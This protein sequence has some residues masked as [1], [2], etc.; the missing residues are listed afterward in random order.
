M[1]LFHFHFSPEQLLLP[2]HLRCNYI[3]IYIPL[4]SIFPLSLSTIFS[5]AA[6]SIMFGYTVYGHFCAADSNTHRND[7]WIMGS[8]YITYDI[9][10]YITVLLRT[11]ICM[12]YRRHH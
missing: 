7:H 4:I 10:I 2:I 3:Y 1:Y 6:F 9:I 12:V 8:S 5:F 11:Y